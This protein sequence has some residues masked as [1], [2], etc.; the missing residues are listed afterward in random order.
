MNK[1]TL[2]NV[3]KATGLAA[4]VAGF[5]GCVA[6]GQQQ[7]GVNMPYI[8]QPG[9]GQWNTGV[10]FWNLGN[11]AGAMNDGSGQQELKYKEF[12][13]NGQIY[14]GYAKMVKGFYRPHGKGVLIYGNV[15]KYEGEFFEGVRQGQGR[16][17]L[18]S[19]SVLDGHWENDEFKG[20]QISSK[21]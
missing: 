10:G 7:G 2:S 13:D 20:S 8:V 16:F 18:S 14:K 5:G 21:D 3:L 9:F 6:P 17:T 11:S 4:I 1:R 12:E 15:G 19:G